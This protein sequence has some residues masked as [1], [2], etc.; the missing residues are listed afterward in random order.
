MYA[1]YHGPDGLARDR[2]RR[3]HRLRRAA[4]RRAARRRRRGGRTSAFF[5]TV[6]VA[7]AGPGRRGRARPRE[8]AASTCACVDADTSAISHRRDHRR[9]RTSRAVCDGVRRRGADVDALDARRR[10]APGRRCA[11]R[12]RSS[13][14]RCSTRTAPRPRC[15]ATC[16]GSSDRDSRSTAAMIPLGSCTMKL[17]ATTEMEPITWPEF[18]DLHPF[19]PARAGRRLR[20]S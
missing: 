18:A 14:T 16:A 3:T 6:T 11:R 15:C 13:P 19:A 8:R 20:S 2:R 17:N 7:R 12:R 1:V 10:R 9:A 4:G 5:D